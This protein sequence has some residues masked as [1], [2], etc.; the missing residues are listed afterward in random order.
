MTTLLQDYADGH[1]ERR[2]NATAI[3]SGD[4]TVSYGDLGRISN[5][6]GR[7]FRELGCQR[8][9]RIA[10]LIP[11]SPLAI[12]VMLGALKAGGVYVPLDPEGPPERLRRMVQASR[13][14]FVLAAGPATEMVSTLLSTF[15]ESRRPAL[16]V[17]EKPDALPQGV[18]AT[19]TF[20]DVLSSDAGPI[21]VGQDASD[22][23]YILFTS[24]STGEPKGVVITH[25]NVIRFVEWARRYFGMSRS[26]R[27]SGH[28]PLHFDLSTFDVF[29]TFAAGAT[30]YPVP[31]E[32]NLSPRELLGFIEASA[33]TQWFSVPSILTYVAKFDALNGD[34]L[35]SLK[36]LL[37]CGE[38]FPTRQLRYWME[39]L[40][41]VTFTNLYGPTEAT[42]ASSYYTMPKQPSSDTEP[43][44]IG[45]A[46]DGEE[47]LVLG[48]DLQPVPR[49][50]IGDLYIGGEGLSPGYWENPDATSSAFRIRGDGLQT[51]IYRT[52][53]LA[54]VDDRN[55]VHFHGRTDSQIKS[56]GHR[57]ELGEVETAV[58]ALDDIHESAVVALETSGFEGF[59][60]ACAYACVEGATLTPAK[61]RSA[62]RSSIPGYM[63]PSRWMEL[64]Q[65]PAN[66]NG[67]IDRPCIRRMFQDRS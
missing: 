24:G 23:A 60:I 9:D 12:I 66:R 39:R 62:L 61:I 11:K 29:G 4:E 26:D 22:A 48:P 59:S 25:G 53:D 45:Q 1:A 42:I 40:P 31:P 52:G 8:G 30:L 35:P 37:W 27:V 65:L 13:P 46:C 67:K 36:R 15:P 50:T 6:L 55:L 2:P 54:S 56:R 38:V 41:H 7:L 57:I 32:L 21:R 47:L 44:P 63:L 3:V 10:F 16:G 28:S 51:R 14:R 19:F 17:L 64:D 20:D 58:N 33:L 34:A 43:V 5:Q 18:E 49:G